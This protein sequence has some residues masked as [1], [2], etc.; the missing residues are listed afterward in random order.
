MLNYTEGR[1]CPS[2]LCEWYNGGTHV[3][4]TEIA[5]C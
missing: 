1:F 5:Q 4:K 2:V 3:S